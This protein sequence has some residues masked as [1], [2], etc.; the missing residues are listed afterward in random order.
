MP[1][2]N[3]LVI[4][5]EAPTTE[6]ELAAR[7]T[8][9]SYGTL[10]PQQAGRRSVPSPWARRSREI[11]DAGPAGG[12]DQMADSLFPRRAEALAGGKKLLAGVV[13]LCV[14]VVCVATWR[15][16]SGLAPSVL[17]GGADLQKDAKGIS[18][19]DDEVD[20]ALAENNQLVN[21]YHSTFAGDAAAPPAKSQCKCD[22][23]DTPQFSAK[24]KGGQMLAQLGDNVFFGPCASCPCMRTNSLEGQVEQLT[25]ELAADTT[26]QDAVKKKELERIPVDI[27]IRQGPK[28]TGGATG[29]VGFKG[30]EG[31]NGETG[32]QVRWGSGA[33]RGR[34]IEGLGFRVELEFRV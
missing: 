22:C 25:K 4:R 28:G 1:F 15:L 29:P 5:E 23:G 20:K 12:A 19:I 30:P 7:M 3:R 10:P 14:A 26:E 24:V 16:D 21:K 34:G 32:Y 11:Q 33:D 8:P 13:V 6:G 18:S 27:V 9:S 31:D 17:L 2:L